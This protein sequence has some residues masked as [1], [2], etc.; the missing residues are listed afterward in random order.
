[1]YTTN[2]IV[3][4]TEDNLIG[5][6]DEIEDPTNISPLDMRNNLFYRKYLY[7]KLVMS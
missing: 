3:T 6:N 5:I 1:M 4:S 2:S 7:N